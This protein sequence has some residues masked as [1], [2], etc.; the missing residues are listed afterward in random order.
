MLVLQFKKPF[1][2]FSPWFLAILLYPSCSP[3]DGREMEVGVIWGGWLS[4]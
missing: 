1:F 4:G 2:F 3:A